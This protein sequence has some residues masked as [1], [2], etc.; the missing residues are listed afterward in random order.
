MEQSQSSSPQGGGQAQIRFGVYN[1][2]GNHAGK[3]VKQVRDSVGSLWGV[4]KDANAFVGKDKV[5][6]DYIIQPGDN[7][8]FH[9]R[10]GEK[11]RKLILAYRRLV[12]KN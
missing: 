6:D 3:T 9:R 2:P 8:E 11:G 4:P 12:G 5:G 1:Q 7:I 10:A